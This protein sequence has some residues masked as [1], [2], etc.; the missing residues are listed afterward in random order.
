MRYTLLLIVLM[1]TNGISFAQVD[2]RDAN[3]LY[4]KG[5]Y[6]MAIDEY[7][8][9]LKLERDDPTYNFRLGVCYLKTNLDRKRASQYF[10]RAKA[11]GKY[12]KELP[13]YYG[14]ALAINYELDEAIASL[15]EYLSSPGKHEEEAKKRKKDCLMAKELMKNPAE[16]TFENMGDKINSSEPDYYPFISGDERILSYTSRRKYKGKIEYDGYYPSDVYL[17]TYNGITF[18]EGKVMKSFN[19]NYNDQST[20]MSLDGETM[21][22]YSDNNPKGELFTVTK[23][24]GNSF[25]KKTKITR[26]DADDFLESA[27][28]ISPDGQTIIFSSNNTKGYESKEDGVA[29][30]EVSGGFDLWIMRKLPFGDNAWAVPQN[31]GSGVNSAGNEDFPS[32]AP[33]GTTIYFASDGLTGMGGWDLFSIEWDPENNTFTEPKNLGYPLNT[34]DDERSISFAA[35]GKHAY[36]SAS[37]KDGFGD[38]DIY[39]ITY[40]LVEVQPA[41]FSIKLKGTDPENP[42]VQAE[43]I[44]I[45][46]KNDELVG[47]YMPNPKTL[48]YTIIL[49]PGEYK[50]EIDA[51]SIGYENH[52]APL[53]VHEFMN[54]MGKIDKFI[55]LK[56][57]P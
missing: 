23:D 12:D 28:C 45:L 42:F 18:S 13:Y 20:G 55:T 49:P 56:K 38:L 46:N 4:K 25:K 51:E 35:D 52:S 6:L 19:S 7:K 2:H 40:E 39:R 34:P 54:Q 27:M 50:I 29:P 31:I 37:R 41:L 53:K 16:V 26:I 24:G 17:A 3:E 1:F 14:V 30:M 33:N 32:F 43:L 10:A 9:L 57:K 48:A 15:D 47:E 22:F 11:T 36:I 21:F 5:N 8:K 44:S